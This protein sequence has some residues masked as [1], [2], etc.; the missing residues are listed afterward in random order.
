M[1]NF[2]NYYS[3]G[4]GGGGYYSTLYNAL[5]QQQMYSSYHQTVMYADS[6]YNGM[7]AYVAPVVRKKKKHSLTFLIIV[8]KR[9]MTNKTI[10]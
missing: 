5:Q 4:G 10:F 3:G 2:D 7:P 1:N 8:K 9:V 6:T